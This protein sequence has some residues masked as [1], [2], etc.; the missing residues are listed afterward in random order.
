V[1]PAPE[2]V[3]APANIDCSEYAAFLAVMRKRLSRNSRLVGQKLLI[4]ADIEAAFGTLDKE[5]DLVVSDAASTVF[6]S[7]AVS[8]SG[9]LAGLVVLVAQSRLVWQCLREAVPT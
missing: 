8:Q 1:A 9:R 6:L 3:A 4:Q 7:T 2:A 5:A